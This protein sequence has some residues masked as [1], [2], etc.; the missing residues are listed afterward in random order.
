MVAG[1]MLA[2]IA[3]FVISKEYSRA[4]VYSVIAA[5][6]SLVGLIH[7]PAG[8]IFQSVDGVF[9]IRQPE[10]IWIGYLFAAVVI[11]TAAWREGHGTMAELRDAVSTPPAADEVAM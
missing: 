3:Y 4:I 7:D 8:L 9:Q 5:G 10:P 2:A 6:L 11:W 1:L